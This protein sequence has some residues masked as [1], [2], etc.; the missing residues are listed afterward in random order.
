MRAGFF[1]RQ[2]PFR[3]TTW[4]RS[5]DPPGKREGVLRKEHF[6]EGQFHDTIVMGILESEYRELVKTW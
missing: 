5:R 6:S 1:T 2:T 4:E 3:M